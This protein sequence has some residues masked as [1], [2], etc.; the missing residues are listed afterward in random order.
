[1]ALAQS[2]KPAL[3]ALSHIETGPEASSFAV[4]PTES[5]C[6]YCLQWARWLARP[7]VV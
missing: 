5:Y 6:F 3:G 1:M 2:K 4:F 7:K